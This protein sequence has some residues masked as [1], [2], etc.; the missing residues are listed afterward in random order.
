MED[1]PQHCLVSRFVPRLA[2]D[3]TSALPRLSQRP[4]GQHP[5]QLGHILLRV[6]AVHA[7]GVQLH[8][9]ARIVFVEALRGLAVIPGARGGLRVGTHA[10]PVVQVPQHRRTLC[11]G[12]QQVAERSQRP[13]T[14][15]VALIRRHQI[16]L[17]ALAEKHVEVI[18]PEVGHYLL[19]LPLAIGRAQQLALQQLAVHH[20]HRIFQ[21][22]QQLLLLRSHIGGQL[23]AVVL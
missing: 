16:P 5:R 8:H 14:N 2:K 4:S 19:Q 21:R 18:E 6:A 3:E 23:V 7:Q 13:W 10:L 15:H 17:R 11:R 12:Q 20:R 22:E 9:L 1:P